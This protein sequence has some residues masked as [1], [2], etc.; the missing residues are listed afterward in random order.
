MAPIP[1]EDTMTETSTRSVDSTG[2]VWQEGPHGEKVV[3]EVHR[4]PSGRF[5]TVMLGKRLTGKVGYPTFAEAKAEALAY[6]PT[7]EQADALRRIL[8]PMGHGDR[9]PDSVRPWEVPA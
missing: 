8:D 6:E 9:T 4:T 1:E 7:G 3:G 2:L 5:Y